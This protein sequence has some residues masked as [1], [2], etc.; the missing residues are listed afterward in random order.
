M[1]RWGGLNSVIGSS[2]FVFRPV[3]RYLD[4]GPWFLV[5]CP[6]K[7]REVTLKI[8]HSSFLPYLLQ[9]GTPTQPVVWSCITLQ[10]KC[11]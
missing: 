9:F 2:L 6:V 7:L 3:I 5:I 11:R 1:S 8:S 4:R 10:L